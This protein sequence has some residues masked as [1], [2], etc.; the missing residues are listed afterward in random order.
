M[1][2]RS[3]EFTERDWTG[4]DSKSEMCHLLQYLVSCLQP[5]CSS[6]MGLMTL[7]VSAS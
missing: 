5:G 2:G 6:T 3:C 7:D 1:H 4:T